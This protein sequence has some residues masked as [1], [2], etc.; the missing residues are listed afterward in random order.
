MRIGILTPHFSF[1]YG[2]VLQA[3]A[4]K[5]YIQSLGHDAI[6]INRRPERLCAIPSKL[7]RLARFIEELAKQKSFGIFEKLENAIK[8]RDKMIEHNWDRQYY[9]DNILNAPEYENKYLY[10]N[11]GKYPIMRRN[12]NGVKTITSSLPGGTKKVKE[13]L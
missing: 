4:L 3:F 8:W 1:N 2:A 5:T 6:L 11:R 12:K 7:G 13:K 9:E 10:L